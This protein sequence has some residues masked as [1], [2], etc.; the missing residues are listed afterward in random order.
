MENSHEN[1]LGL[2]KEC[3]QEFWRFKGILRIFGK[4]LIGSVVYIRTTDKNKQGL[5]KKFN[6]ISEKKMIIINYREWR[7]VWW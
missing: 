3:K 6:N 7:Q 4:D 2:R 1:L 5:L